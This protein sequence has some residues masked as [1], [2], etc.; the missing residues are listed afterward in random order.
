MSFLTPWF[1][2]GALAVAG[3]IVFHLIRRSAGERMPFSS[4]MF[5]MPVPPRATRRRKLEH[6]WLLLLRCLCLLLLATGFA[7]PFF[8]HNQPLPDAIVDGRQI[9]LL[10]DTSASMRRDGVW[11]K[12]RAIAQSY[13]DKAAPADE[14]A[15]LTF[16]RQLRTIVNMPEWSSWSAEQRSV[17]ARQRLAAVSPGWMGTQMGLALT[18]AAEQFDSTGGKSAKSRVLVLISDLQEGARLDGLQGHEWPANTRVV[19]ERV[20]AG[21]ESNA[22]LE[23]LEPSANATS[24]ENDIHVRVANSSDSHK[25]KFHLNWSGS[26]DAMEIYLPP[27]QSRTFTAPKISTNMISGKLELS[28]DDVDFDNAAYFVAPE[29]EVVKIVYFGADSAD[30]PAGLRYYLQ[31][32]FQPTPRREIKFVP[33]ESLSQS[34]FAIVPGKLGPEQCAALRDWLAGGKSALLV[35]TNAEAAP[36]LATL[37]GLPDVQVTEAAG[38]FALLGQVDFKHPI[39]APFD[40]PRYS[41]FS[42]IHFWKH[43]RWEIPPTLQAS[44]LAKFDDESPALTQIAIGKGQLLVLASG[45]DPADSQLA[46]SSKFPP[47]MQTMLQ[48][49]GSSAAVH[50]Q[51]RTGDA[52]PSPVLSGNT[53]QWK[54]P[55]GKMVTLPAGTP[56]V[57]TDMPGIYHAIAENRDRQFAVNL[58]LEESRIAPLAQDELARLGVPLGPIADQNI[59]LARVH[60]QQLAQSELENR[61]KLWRWLLAGALAITLMEIVLGGRLARRVTTVEAAT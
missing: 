34:D 14:L 46:V 9:I 17:L 1:L 39:F 43:R 7:R 50:S 10:L 37:L 23:I 56:F 2:F 40:D 53:V 18:G 42:H 31:R 38:D 11:E 44:V 57:E 26:G 52:I 28:G 27:G 54:K 48:W 19:I 35:L 47:L 22:G 45:W 8:A 49:S 12:A 58:P 41:D 6:L 55:D 5:L 33:G 59:K 24:V 16:D 15:I 25:E 36:T 32:V 60:Q 29:T 30:E 20:Q 61:Q 4:L 13:L 51:F 3:P 21:N